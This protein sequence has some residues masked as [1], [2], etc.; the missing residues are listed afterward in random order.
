M[1]E[2][3]D[4]DL[5]RIE[6]L[7]EV[8]RSSDFPGEAAN[9]LAAARRIAADAGYDLDSLMA[10]GPAGAAGRLD[11]GKQDAA[12]ERRKAAAEPYVAFTTAIYAAEQAAK[13]ARDRARLQAEA[14]RVQA[15]RTAKQKARSSSRRPDPQTRDLTSPIMTR[16]RQRLDRLRRG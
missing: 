13:L 7:L 6:K 16:Y 2:L 5:L 3:S 9:A 4:K 11:Q 12:A 8:S 15:E 10:A 14:R 1:R